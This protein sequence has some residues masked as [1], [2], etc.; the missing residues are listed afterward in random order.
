MVSPLN[1]AH[2]RFILRVY[3]SDENTMDIPLAGDSAQSAAENLSAL[4]KQGLQIQYPN[5]HDGTVLYINLAIAAYW[6][7]MENEFY[8]SPEEIER[9]RSQLFRDEL[10]RQEEEALLRQVNNASVVSDAGSS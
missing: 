7:V 3:Y 6:Q 10:L 8:V 1:T 9:E 4:Q 2:S 5:D